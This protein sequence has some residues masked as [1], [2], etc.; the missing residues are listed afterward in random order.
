MI[1][2]FLTAPEH[3]GYQQVPAT[4][5]ETDVR[6]HFYLTQAD[7][8]AVSQQRRDSNRLGWAVQL[9]LVRL[10]GYLPEDWP[11]QVPRPLVQFVGQQLGTAPEALATYGERAATRS[12]HLQQVLTYLGFRK[13]QPLD[14]PGLEAWLLERALEHDQPRLL[15]QAAC[16]KLRQDRLLRPAIS[17]LEHL[18]SQALLQTD[19]ATYQRLAP[20]LTLTVEAQLDALLLLDPA[21]RVTPH[22]WLCQPATAN[23]PAAI[24]QALAKLTYLSE[25]GISI[26][27]TVGLNANRRKRLAH[28]TR[29]RTSQVL[30]RYAPAKRYPLLA[31][32]KSL[33]Q[34]LSEQLSNMAATR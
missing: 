14:G 11:Q 6:Q 22:R 9:G 28:Q 3:Q 1:I 20:L 15:L 8:A 30:S 13:W 12:E 2:P 24:N 29:H 21:L 4:L 25:L 10:M 17:V 23:T 18:V 27:D 33:V 16:Q 32:V 7:L 26:W 5:S 19:A 34:K 31:L